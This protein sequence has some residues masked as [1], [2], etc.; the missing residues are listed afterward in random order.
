MKTL[1]RNGR[2]QAPMHAVLKRAR[3]G[4]A[5]QYGRGI[6]VTD[7]DLPVIE[8]LFAKQGHPYGGDYWMQGTNQHNTVFLSDFGKLFKEGGAQ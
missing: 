7:R 2:H 5:D 6:W 3:I 8:E 4:R 1:V